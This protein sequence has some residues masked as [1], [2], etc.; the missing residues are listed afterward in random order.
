MKTD[1]S[2]RNI[3]VA[4]IKRKTIK[5]FDFTF[6]KVFEKERLNE[7]GNDFFKFAS[8]SENELPIAQ[9]LVDESNWTLGTTRQVISCVE[10]NSKS[11]YAQ[12]IKRWEWGDFKGYNTTP[13]TTGSFKQTMV[14]Y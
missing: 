6:T 4:S 13:F 1:N 10:G 11:I 14:K 12:D 5:P 2:I 3:S 8:V 9:T 7:V